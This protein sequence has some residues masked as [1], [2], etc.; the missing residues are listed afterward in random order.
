RGIRWRMLF[1]QSAPDV[2]LSTTTG[3]TAIGWLANSILPLRGGEVLRAAVV[4]RR[5]KV[6]LVTSA[7]TVALERVLDL[8]GLALVAAAALLLLTDVA[9]L[10]GWMIAALE[11]AWAL[12]IVALVGLFALVRFRDA[13]LRLSERLTRRL[14]KVGAKLHRLVDL[15]LSGL[16]ALVARPRL[17]AALMPL[18]LAVAVC[19]SLVFTFLVL[20]FVPGTP[21]A[22]AFAGASVFLMSFIVSVTPGNVG[23]YEAAFV[24]VFVALGVPAGAAVPAAVLTHLATTLIVA[25]AG[26]AALLALG[27]DA[28]RVFRPARA[29]APGG[30]P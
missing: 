12:P 16:A 14:G 25:V 22:L 30:S 10:P 5:D 6:S 11:V 24:A 8:M 2:R 20:S 13:A 21:A 28:P 29:P 26:S 19:Q 9:A 7:A 27:M 23:T 1:A 3:A 17:L 15:V 18:T 4:A